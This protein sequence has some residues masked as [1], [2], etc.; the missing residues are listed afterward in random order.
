MWQIKF[1]THIDNRKDYNSVYFIF[2]SETTKGKTED[3]E[4]N[5]TQQSIN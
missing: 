3:S 2:M 5:G 4:P 1:S